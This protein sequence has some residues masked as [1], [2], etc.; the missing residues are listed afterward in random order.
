MRDRCKFSHVYNAQF[1]LKYLC[2][3]KVELQKV[4][5]NALLRGCGSVIVVTNQGALI[6]DPSSGAFDP[7]KLEL[8]GAPSVSR[9]FQKL[10]ETLIFGLTIHDP[11]S[12]N[13][14]NQLFLW[15]GG[16]SITQPLAHDHMITGIEMIT[17]NGGDYI[18]SAS[19]DK[20]MRAWTIEGPVLK[21]MEEQIFDCF[22]NDL[23]QVN[24]S[25]VLGALEN[26]SLGVWNISANSTS[27]L[28]GHDHPCVKIIV[29]SQN[30]I[31]GDRAG[32]V[33]VRDLTSNLL[34]QVNTMN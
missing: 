32:F 5:V 8:P 22:I 19:K 28:K 9:S 24:D 14:D 31:S 20:R 10:G 1:A 13:K 3:V 18:I 7:Q 17:V 4:K 21:G 23:A 26:G 34:Y 12:R 6:F 16:A 15:N 30:I 25:I 2:S 27:N 33:Q 11:A 29:T